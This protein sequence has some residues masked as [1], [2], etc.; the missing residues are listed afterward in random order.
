M[1][2]TARYVALSLAVSMTLGGCGLADARKQAIADAQVK[3]LDMSAALRPGLVGMPDYP[4]TGWEPGDLN[5]D[6]S[7][8]LATIALQAK[9][10]AADYTVE[11]TSDGR[12]LGVPTLDFCGATF[13]SESLRV[14]RLQNAAF[15]ADGNFT[16]IS[17]EVVLYSSAAA[18]KQALHE[19]T[20]ARLKCPT[21]HAVSTED[22]HSILFTF[23]G[24]PGP[25]STPLT[26]PDARLIIHTSMKVDGSPRT[27][28]LAYQIDGKVLAG[29]YIT[30][31]IAQPFDQSSLDSFYA[32]A[33]D[34]ANRL[35][36]YNS[37]KTTAV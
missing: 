37:E 26:G 21:D 36:A 34:I 17:S 27:S 9:D 29:L 24:A 33:G 4:S 12:S 19:V 18:A 30:D 1:F 16:G 5:S 7:K 22:G 15:D 25:S 3:P 10:V 28:F 31:A 20:Q 23:H 11:V 2:R 6:A 35:R 8:S 32:L 13:P 14:A